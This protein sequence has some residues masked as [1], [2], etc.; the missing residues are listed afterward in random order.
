VYSSGP[1]I[2]QGAFIDEGFGDMPI[3]PVLGPMS[4]IESSSPQPTIIPIMII[5]KMDIKIVALLKFIIHRSC[6]D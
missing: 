5:S 6:G 2:L 3:V 1:A 4:V